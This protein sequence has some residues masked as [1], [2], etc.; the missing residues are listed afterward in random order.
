M[1]KILVEVFKADIALVHP[2]GGEGVSKSSPKQLVHFQTICT[3]ISSDQQT[4]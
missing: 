1:A 4:A 3:L 2:G